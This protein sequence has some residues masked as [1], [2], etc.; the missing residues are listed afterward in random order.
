MVE[1]YGLPCPF[2]GLGGS[3]K[4]RLRKIFVSEHLKLPQGELAFPSNFSCKIGLRNVAAAIFLTDTSASTGDE[5]IVRAA[6]G[7]TQ[8]V[9]LAKAKQAT[10]RS[11]GAI[12]WNANQ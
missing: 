1:R 9:L 3:A 11:N 2:R 12:G 8:R 6:T 4:K 5:S 10:M 7:M